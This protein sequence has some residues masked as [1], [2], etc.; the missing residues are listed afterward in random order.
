MWVKTAAGPARS[1]FGARPADGPRH[2]VPGV[3]PVHCTEQSGRPGPWFE[4]LPHFRLEFTPS[5]GD[6]LQT[7]FLVDAADAVA[8]LGA[9]RELGDVLAPVLQVSE[10]RT[11]AADELWLSPA[12]GRAS[13]AVHFTWTDDAAAVAPVVA[14]V[15]RALEPFAPRPHWGKV[16]SLDPATVRSRYPEADRFAALARELDPAGTFRNAFVA[17]YVAQ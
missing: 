4:R 16:F 2:P 17:P 15:E 5:A 7:E 9:V 13:V 11:I 3:D 1:W 14:A 6:E 10:V 8:V 12:S